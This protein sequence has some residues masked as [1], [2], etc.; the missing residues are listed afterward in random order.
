MFAYVSVHASTPSP[1]SATLLSEAARYMGHD[2]QQQY[3]PN[4]PAALPP[5]SPLSV[6][7]LNTL[8]LSDQQ[9]AYLQ[10]GFDCGPAFP[11]TH[12]AALA[13]NQLESPPQP[14]S[15]TSDV[16]MATNSAGLPD[17]E[18]VTSNHPEALLAPSLGPVQGAK[19][20]S[21]F[22]Y[23]SNRQ[24]AA[25]VAQT[26]A[27][28][29]T[30]H[31]QVHATACQP[32]GLVV[33]DVSPGPDGGSTSMCIS[34]ASGLQAQQGLDPSPRGAGRTEAQTVSAPGRLPKTP[35][36]LCDKTASDNTYHA[37]KAAG[38][39]TAAT[40]P[41]ASTSEMAGVDSQRGAVPSNKRNSSEELAKPH[42]VS[43]QLTADLIL[44]GVL[45]EGGKIR[46][47]VQHA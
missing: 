14:T 32:L 47:F 28:A 35:V 20:A 25:A 12:T 19:P 23:A 33:R 7:D 40:D 37:L 42:H 36:K 21:G 43:T 29:N 1:P 26:L 4:Q 8:P 30:G 24:A 41:R 39:L 3:I 13:T 5:P 31:A 46:D 9:Q 27:A 10:H 34:G 22:P 16:V 11:V 17:S 2:L 44:C 38:T 45:Q 18:A 6:Q 15:A